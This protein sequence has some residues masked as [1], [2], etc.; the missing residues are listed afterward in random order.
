MTSLSK[1][2]ILIFK[3]CSDW[4]TSKTAT[5]V[6]NWL[7]RNFTNGI[8]VFLNN[9]N[10][11]RQRTIKFFKIVCLKHHSLHIGNA[12][13]RWST[14]FLCKETLYTLWQEETWYNILLIWW[15]PGHFMAAKIWQICQCGFLKYPT[16][17][18]LVKLQISIYNEHITQLSD[19][20]T[21][22]CAL[23]CEMK[24]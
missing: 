6:F 7:R 8:T 3:H 18:L 22:A 1:M 21:S 10:Y 19:L 14:S 17:I 12:K 24:T 2:G 16:Y 4:C 13:H 5:I 9:V 11:F 23:L 20:S 15:D